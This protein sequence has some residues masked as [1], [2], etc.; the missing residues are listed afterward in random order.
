[1]AG[2]VLDRAME[3]VRSGNDY[4]IS[5]SPGAALSTQ[6]TAEPAAPATGREGDELAAR[7]APEAVGV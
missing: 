6:E 4:P 7:E 5:T 2:G 3:V 1:M